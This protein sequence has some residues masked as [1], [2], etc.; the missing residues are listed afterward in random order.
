MAYKIFIIPFLLLFASAF[1]RGE[2]VWVAP[3]L[4]VNSLGMR[5]QD[6]HFINAQQG[7]TV[8]YLGKVGFIGHTDGNGWRAQFCAPE[9]YPQA[10]QFISERRGW[11]AGMRDEK[12]ILLFTEDSGEHWI[13]RHQF[14]WRLSGL[15]FV[16]E[17]SG[18]AIGF[19]RALTGV[20]LSTDDSGGTWNVQHLRDKVQ[21]INLLV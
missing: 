7:W 3:W 5:I 10:V 20:I 21:F 8:G 6:V 17:R 1:V 9:F 11:V 13:E 4:P 2:G 19:D 16:T 12:G 15:Q 18:W 14:P